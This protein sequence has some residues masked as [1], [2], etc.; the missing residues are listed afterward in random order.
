METQMD[1]L[2]KLLEIVPDSSAETEASKVE[3]K[4]SAKDLLYFINKMKPE[5]KSP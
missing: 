4:I 5:S 3:L 1:K 2:N